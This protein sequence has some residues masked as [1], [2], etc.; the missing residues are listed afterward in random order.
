MPAG[1]RAALVDAATE[2]L[3]EGG[4]D[5]VTLRE[6]GRRAGVSHNAPYKH[7]AS[8]ETLL[9]AV[10]ARDLAQRGEQVAATIAAAATP[11]A[12]LRQVMHEYVRWALHYPSRFKLVFGAWST[13]SAELTDAAH[14]AMAA[15]VGLVATAQDAGALP[16][17]DP[18][19][20]AALL[21]AVAHGAADLAAAGHLS[22]DGKGHA[23]PAELAD[24]LLDH[25]RQAAAGRR[26]RGSRAP[27]D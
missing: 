24:D 3:D 12:A 6:V 11:D 15:L 10:A 16:A 19:R 17:G 21:R 13:E 4:V 18:E 9:A 7:F 2:L 27:A 8:K 14:T 26:R 22:A 5:A 1:T 23:D 20:L 25:L